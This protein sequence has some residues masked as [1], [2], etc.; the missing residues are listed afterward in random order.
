L[1]IKPSCAGRATLDAT[2]TP[3]IHGSVAS[4][5]SLPIFDLTSR[6]IDDQFPELDWVARTLE[7]TGC[8][9]G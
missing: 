4:I 2:F 9:A 3:P 7:T 8:H 1:R 5:V 6:N